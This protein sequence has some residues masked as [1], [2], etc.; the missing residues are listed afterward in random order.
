[1]CECLSLRISDIIEYSPTKNAFV[2]Q[3]GAHNVATLTE[4]TQLHLYDFGIFIQLMPDEEEKSMLENNI[5]VALGQQNIELEDAIDLREIKNIKLANQLLKIRRK[6]KIDRDQKMQQ[7]NMQAQANAN[8]QQQQAAAQFE[9][10]KQETAAN[11][12][13][14][15]ATA[16]NQLEIERL[17]QEA[18][19]KKMLME[20]E[21]EYNMQL[22][23]VESTGRKDVETSKEDRKDERTKIQAT[24]QSQLIDQRQKGGIPKNFE[25]SGNDVMGGIDMSNFGPR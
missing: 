23:R 22:A 3:I 12:A 15:I 19:V 24:Q 18:E 17:Y 11:T 7:E 16:K 6:K 13:I 8:I 4:M 10:Q 20:Q 21:F 5:Q 25:S 2:Q 1:M 9:Q 14:S